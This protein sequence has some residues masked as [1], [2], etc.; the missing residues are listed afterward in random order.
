MK[1]G[2][3]LFFGLL[4]GAYV[5][6]AFLGHGSVRHEHTPVRLTNGWH[7]VPNQLIGADLATLAAVS[8]TEGLHP[9]TPWRRHPALESVDGGTFQYTWQAPDTVETYG[10]RIP[11]FYGAY[12]VYFDGR[13]V[14]GRG[15]PTL[16]YQQHADYVAADVLALPRKSNVVITFEAATHDIFPGGAAS[17]FVVD[18]YDLLQSTEDRVVALTL[19]VIG[20]LTAIGFTVVAAAWDSPVAKRQRVFGGLTIAVAGLVAFNDTGLLAAQWLIVPYAAIYRIELLFLYGTLA[21]TWIYAAEAGG[22]RA[23]PKV[24][25][26]L[27]ISMAVAAALAVVLPMAWSSRVLPV[28][29]VPMMLGCGLVL[30]QALVSR[31]WS[32]PLVALAR[33]SLLALAVGVAVAAVTEIGVDQLRG[34]L[35]LLCFLTFGVLGAAQFI[36]QLVAEEGKLY[37]DAS[38]GEMK[39][40]FMARVSHE[41]RTPLHGISGLS[42]MIRA[43]GPLSQNQ[44]K[45]LDALETSTTAMDVTVAG[46]L[47]YE[48]VRAGKLRLKERQ[49]QLSEVLA[50][51]LATGSL[52]LP[53]GMHIGLRNHSSVEAFLVDGRRLRDALV[54]LLDNA[55]KHGGGFH[56]I[57]H[58]TRAGDDLEIMVRSGGPTLTPDAVTVAFS[59]FSQEG[60]Y[61]KR[62]T[63]GLGIG[64]SMAAVTVE[65]MGGSIQHVPLEVGNGFVL[66]VPLRDVVDEP[67]RS[68]HGF[69][70]LRETRAPEHFPRI[71]ATAELAAEAL[72][73]APTLQEQLSAAVVPSRDP[74]RTHILIVE[75]HPINQLLARKMVESWG[76][77]AEVCA[78][79]QEAI[80]AISPGKFDLVLMDLQMPVLDGISA[81]RKLRELYPA[82][83]LPIVALTAN[84][85]AADREACALVGMQDFLSKPFKSDELKGIVDAL[86]GAGHFV[87]V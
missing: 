52:Q 58:V 79:G 23:F 67:A 51:A 34:M 53:E 21:L 28:A 72:Q 84:S 64:L 47:D 85:S 60:D 81:T 16:D 40:Q 69:E 35:T 42:K 55:V 43:E 9:G 15:T 18:R 86:L 30:G 10:L 49:V 7:F 73:V 62:Q 36:R 59:A 66:R 74:N 83:D 11:A 56:P 77:T 17:E 48:D 71:D 38:A 29:Y 31:G 70:V 5:F 26:G 25:R 80:E 27:V 24:R 13:A 57:V 4:F 20:L 14:G 78:N 6:V 44:L 46:I 3:W 50:E 39:T 33:A 76:F 82:E 22:L 63:G 41:L 54:Q 32:N 87:G 37:A 8:V 2:I 1:K 65:Q 68:V 45:Y 75:D 61:W 12:R 19:F